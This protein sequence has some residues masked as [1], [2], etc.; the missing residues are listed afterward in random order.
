MRPFCNIVP[1]PHIRTLLESL[2]CPL[3][4][5]R[6]QHRFVWLYLLMQV[7]ENHFLK[8]RIWKLEVTLINGILCMRCYLG[9]GFRCLTPGTYITNPPPFQ[10]PFYCAVCNK[11][12]NCEASYRIHCESFKHLQ[13]CNLPIP[14][15]MRKQ[16]EKK[17]SLEQ[18]VWDCRSQPLE[19]GAFGLIICRSAL[20]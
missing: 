18:G 5:R 19:H 1:Q 2:S 11:K 6:F 3:L 17:V 16:R 14:E 13:L 9:A 12:C 7:I 10:L 8:F 20:S 15:K 4:E